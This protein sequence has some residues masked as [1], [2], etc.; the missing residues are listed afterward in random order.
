MEYRDT[1]IS[2]ALTVTFA[3]VHA[4]IRDTWSRPF[5]TELD[6]ERPAPA[7]GGDPSTF[8]AGGGTDDQRELEVDLPT[9]E[10]L[11]CRCVVVPRLQ[12]AVQLSA[13]PAAHWTDK[14]PINGAQVQVPPAY[15][16]AES[17]YHSAYQGRTLAYTPGQVLFHAK[18]GHPPA[19]WAKMA[20]YVRQIW[21]NRAERDRVVPAPEFK[22]T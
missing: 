9:E 19:V 4:P 13:P 7:A 5:S 12:G 6:Y 10:S 14:A 22:G 16:P 8:D 3:Q 1:N 11:N 20:D 15:T 17:A 2:R 18:T 21:E